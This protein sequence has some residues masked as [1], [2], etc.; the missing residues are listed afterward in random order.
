MLIREVLT[1]KA[2]QLV[3]ATPD[4]LIPDAINIMASHDIGSLIIMDRGHMVG[5]IT[6]RDILRALGK[7][8]CD[9]ATGKVSD[10]MVT[11][12]VIGSLEDSVDYVRDVM[13]RSRISH[14]PVLDEHHVVGIISFHDVARACLKEAKFENLLLKRYIKHWPE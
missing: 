14:L 11:D 8:G 3:T 5:L 6:E 12:P 4:T 9:L 2:D 13:T 7:Q 10:V 1:V